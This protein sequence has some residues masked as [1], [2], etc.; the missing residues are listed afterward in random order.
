LPGELSRRWSGLGPAL[1]LTACYGAILLYVPP[2]YE[3]PQNDDWAYYLTL[4][5][6]FDT[7]TLRHLG[8][9]DPTLLFQLLW[10]GLFARLF[11]LTYTSLRWSTLVLSWA[12][13]LGLYAILRRCGIARPVALL[14]AGAMLFQPMFLVLSYSFNTDVPYLSLS[15]LAIL[16]FLQ[17]MDADRMRW[18]LLAGA[19]M[20]CAFLV[21]QQ[22]LL[23]ALGAGGALWI[24]R[25]P[26]ESRS[27]RRSFA[28]TAAILA[29][30]FAA[31]VVFVAWFHRSIEGSW[32]WRMSNLHPFFHQPT[33]GGLGQLCIQGIRESAAGMLG[34]AIPALPILAA[35]MRGSVRGLRRR[36]WLRRAFLI[37]LVL[38]IAAT[39]WFMRDQRPR[40]RGWPYQGNYLTRNGPLPPLAES[41]WPVPRWI[42]RAFTD[43][44]PLLAAWLVAGILAAWTKESGRRPSRGAAL[45]IALGVLQLLAS[46][47]V[48]NVYDRYFILLLPLLALA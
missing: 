43:A 4:Q 34:L 1:L 47:A 38:L 30:V 39:L 35:G 12:G 17:A 46:L 37:A 26:T 14:G 32:P 2:A 44:A 18:Y 48:T 21:R 15:L 20:A 19:A 25:A 36:P 42:W 23:L 11:G 9:N 8:W 24:G 28:A 22:G 16:C 29:P 31:A 33:P 13:V 45:V 5:R 40:L 7:G 6:W 10:G 3:V 41:H 27:P